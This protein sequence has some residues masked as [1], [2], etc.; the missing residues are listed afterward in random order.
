MNNFFTNGL[1]FD[2][3]YILNDRHTLR[4][5]LVAENTLEK[6][7]TN[8][9]VFDTTG[10]LPPDVPFSIPDKSTNESWSSGLYLQDEWRIDARSHAELRPALRS[11][12]FQFRHEDQWSPRANLVW[13]IDDATTAHAGYARYF[14]PPPPQNLKQS[15]LQKF[16]GT[17]NEPANFLDDPPRVERSNYYDVGISRQ[18]TRPWA[19]NLD[20]FYKSSKNLIDQGQF[21]APVILSTFNYETGSVYGAELS[22]N[23]KQD[24]FSAFGN[25]S[26]VMTSG[27]RHRLPAVPHRQRQAGVHPGPQHP[28]RPRIGIYGLRR[29][30]L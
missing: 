30:L 10:A 9:A 23:Y 24:G 15:S 7:N 4:G 17:T 2:S 28:P 22:S 12:R 18:I 3:S 16:A 1:Q 27:R 21:G 13:K 6:L 20:G 26:W 8:T 5:G 29:R 14:V 19:V 25:F 11:L